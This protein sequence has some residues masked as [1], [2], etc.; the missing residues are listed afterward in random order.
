MSAGLVD[1]PNIF[2]S[3]SAV[4]SSIN[5][6]S[7]MSSFVIRSDV[8]ELLNVDATIFLPVDGDFVVF[9]FLHVLPRHRV[10]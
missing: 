9:C 2:S 5:Q 10:G 3:D 7:G 4:R 8:G 1:H 6:R